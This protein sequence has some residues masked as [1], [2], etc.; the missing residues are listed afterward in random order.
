MLS[1]GYDESTIREELERNGY[2][3]K[4]SEEIFEHAKKKL[5]DLGPKP[6][7]FI[8]PKESEQAKQRQQ[9]SFNEKIFIALYT[10]F[11]FL[12]IAWTVYRTDSPAGVIAISF[13]PVIITNPL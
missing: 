2:S 4:A 8:V 13:V 1:A 10:I 5:E 7:H 6:R 3:P 9:L 12:L 11:V